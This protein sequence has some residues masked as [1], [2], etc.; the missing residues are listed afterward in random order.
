MSARL[1][2]WAPD[3]MGEVRP[4]DDLATLVGDLLD[5]E[6]L[7]EAD[8]V[9]V[10]SKVVSKAEGRVVAA[11]DREQAIT[12]ETV[13]VVATRAR[14]GAAPLRIVE[15]RLG[16]VMAAAGVDA[17]NTPAGTVLLLPVDPDASARALR[18][19]L[20]ARFGIDRLG[21]VVT[22]TAGRAWRD[23]LVDIAIGAAGVAV[24]DDLRGGVDAH[25]RPLSVTV[26]AVVDEIA[27]ASELVRGKAAGRPVAV[28]RGLG[29]HVP[30]GWSNDGGAR[31]L[32]RG[33]PDDLF[34][35]GVAEAYA[36]GHA[37]GVAGLTPRP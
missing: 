32:V 21:V 25:G 13:R 2:V 20:R 7:T 26:T 18:E 12:D 23:G 15:N 10:T 33:G 28:V 4:G 9:V 8:V 35:E 27:A 3:G 6:G 30:S 37:D 17:S 22:D 14:P 5:A 19:A 11:D 1:T 34:R 29:R 24:V 31:R 36:R 16:L